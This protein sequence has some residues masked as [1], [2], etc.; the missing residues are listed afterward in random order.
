MR[1]VSWN[2]NGLRACQARGFSKWLSRCGADVVGLQEVRALPEQLPPELR[3]PKRW[4]AHYSAAQRPGYSGVG[5]LSRHPFG[6]VET[7]LD[8]PEIDAEGLKAFWLVSRAD[9]DGLLPIEITPAPRE[10]V[11]VGLVIESF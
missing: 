7:S 1:V 8:H 4:H 3:E 6:S 9:Y 2:V 5:L 10:M 11:R